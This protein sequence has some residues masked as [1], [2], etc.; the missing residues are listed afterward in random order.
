[1]K[2]IFLDIDGVLNNHSRYG[3]GSCGINGIMMARLNVLLEDPNVRIVLSGAWRY[4]IIGGAMTIKGFNLMMMTHG[5]SA[6]VII[7]LTI[8][9]EMIIK[10]RADQ[11]KCWLA[12]HNNYGI[13]HYV[14]LDDLDLKVDNFVKVDGN[15]GLSPANINRALELLRNDRIH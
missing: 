4:M 15:V 9:D 10:D 11:I 12:A 6:Q 3:N 13:T 8:A 14:V 5:L 2:I 1:M 7:D